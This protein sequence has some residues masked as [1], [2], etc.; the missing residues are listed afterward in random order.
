MPLLRVCAGIR[1]NSGSVPRNKCPKK[2]LKQLK[3]NGVDELSWAKAFPS[4][5][6]WP[7]RVIGG[8]RHFMIR[9]MP[10]FAIPPKTRAQYIKVLFPK[11]L[12]SMAY[13]RTA[14]IPLRFD[15]DEDP[16]RILDCIR[17]PHVLDQHGR[18]V[19]SFHIRQIN[20]R[21]S[22]RRVKQAF[23]EWIDGLPKKRPLANI[24]EESS[25]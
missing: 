1:E 17:R 13:I 2:N 15:A 19:S 7:A 24:A 10:W 11:H 5:P 25:S 8:F 18:I 22:K 9:E 16:Q 21:H 23:A 4:A 20:Q 14:V 6:I 3:T 12:P